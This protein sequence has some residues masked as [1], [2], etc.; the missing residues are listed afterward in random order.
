MADDL[1]GLHEALGEWFVTVLPIPSIVGIEPQAIAEI[2]AFGLMEGTALAYVFLC[3]LV[4][5]PKWR[6]FSIV[7]FIVL[8]PLILSGIVLDAVGVRHLESI[9]EILSMS[10]L[11]AYVHVQLKQYA[12]PIS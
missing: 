10:A 4:A 11:L 7:L 2:I 12:R 9:G 6:K 3:T 8:T 5:E 1:I